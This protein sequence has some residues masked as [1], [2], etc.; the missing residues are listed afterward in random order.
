MSSLPEYDPLKPEIPGTDEEVHS[1]PESTETWEAEQWASQPVPTE[2]ASAQSEQPYTGPPLFESWSQPA[3]L[4]PES[5]PHLGH[6][7]ILAVLGILGWFGSGLLTLSALHFHLFGVSTLEQANNNFSYTLGFQVTSY[8]ITFG[9][10]LL[11]FPL[12]W[13]EGFFEGLQWNGTTAL[14]LRRRLLGAASLCFILA[15]VNGLMFKDP[16]DAPIDKLFR[17]P[18]AA[19]LLFA[20]GVTCAPFFEEIA[21]RGF[22]LPALCTAWDWSIE[23][24]TGKAPLP[25]DEKGRPQWSIFGMVVGSIATSI[26][27]AMI[28]AQ[29]N[30]H[31][32]GPLLL[33]VCVSL[34]LC[35]VRLR[36]G[37]LAAS[38]V[39]HACYNFLLFSLMLLGTGGFRHLEKM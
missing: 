29:Q 26:P 9:A 23:R 39:V 15:I 16:T 30:G 2:P 1:P 18:G 3:R 22:L 6:V 38:V 19:W 10:C 32:F 28:H 37:S 31:A 24:S 25:L 17:T 34:V 11:V 13:H 4:R 20:F 36:T 12:V 7:F 8:L 14:R 35:W 27:F 21:F 5:I 33:L